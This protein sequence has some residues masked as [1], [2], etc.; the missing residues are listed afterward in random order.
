MDMKNTIQLH[1][2]SEP[3]SLDPVRAEDGAGLKI[4]SNLYE[5]LFTYDSKGSLVRALCDA[6]EVSK[7]QLHYRFKV[8]E[9]AKWSDGSPLTAA[10]FV[11]GIK[12]ALDP[13]MP[14]KMSDILYVIRGAKDYRLGKSH[15]ENELGVRAKGAWLEID[16]ERPISYLREILALMVASPFD[17][18]HPAM[19]NGPYTIKER[20]LDS[21][22]LLEP[23]PFYWK[24]QQAKPILIRV[25]QD[26]STAL[27]LFRA[28]RL[29]VV[30][31]IPV[32]DLPK[33]KGEGVVQTFPWWV[34]YYLAFNI[35][36][37]PSDNVALR[38]AIAGAINKKQITDWLGGGE[39]PADG[40]V[41]P[42]I[43]GY[44]IEPIALTKASFNA[45][46]EAK[47][48]IETGYDINARNNGILEK[49]QADL[50]NHLGVQLKL[51]GQEWKSYVK[52]LTDDAPPL[53][54]F[55]WL[56]AFKDPYAHLQI[57]MSTNPNNYTG[58]KNKKYD[59]L[60]EKI[61]RLTAATPKQE[62]EK[63]HLVEQAEK[64]LTQED[65]V[66]IPIFHYTQ[67]Y[68]VNPKL[69]GF[70]ANPFGIIRY[71]ELSF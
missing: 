28:G 37:S 69:K 57:F 68:A 9:G 12:R 10:H 51:S 60:V 30:S 61:G 47:I 18:S 24:H 66:V 3:V 33:L 19:G 8:R 7:D 6:E 21:H 32:L 62:N 48:E 14:A 53:Y 63:R 56:A 59:E 44:D 25:V 46:R 29:D 34:T 55:G 54:R 42:G 39:R 17:S 70:A 27:N 43:G 22:I 49:I 35:R 71:D 64:L 2:S 40:F 4:I 11:A 52:R 67:T 13:K 23:N 5:G 20:V 45:G 58:W 1:L 26:E 16:L 36:K 31:R 41:P 50:K 65:A 15:S 38:R